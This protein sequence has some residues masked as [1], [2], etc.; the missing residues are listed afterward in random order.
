ML[1]ATTGDLK[2]GQFGMPVQASEV[3]PVIDNIFNFITWICIFF[4]VIIV[5]FIVFFMFKYSKPPG[6]PATSNVTHNTPIEVAWTVLPL[7]LVIFIF[8]K[9][10][11]GYIDLRSAPLGAYEVNVVAQK[12]N[13]TFHYKNGATTSVLIVPANRPVKLIMSSQ[14]VLHAL[15]IPD[16]RVKQDVVP[17]RI[18]TLW[19]TAI[20]AGEYDLYCAEYCGQQHSTML[21]KVIVLDDADFDTRITEEANYIDKIPPDMLYVAGP[22][23]YMRC[24]SCH[25]LDGSDMTGPTWQGLWDRTVDGEQVFTDGTTLSNLMG[26]GKLFDGP[27]DYVTQ[28]IN[29]PQQKIRM[30][31][32]GSMPTFKGQL[33][34]LEVMAIIDFLKHLDK[35]DTDGN[36][37]DS[38]DDLATIL[39]AAKA[40][41]AA[42][43]NE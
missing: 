12:W 19:F 39:D 42:S 36:P 38:A 3:A 9:G 13:W 27:E 30:N 34:P 21:T 16:F 25:S 14:D 7:I 37:L 43:S 29:N 5:G 1:L 23:L 15:F 10:M 40:A 35:F 20:K 4:F 28:S 18:T 33:G 2:V 6:T 41:E 32:S 31:Y 8:Y 22:R 26:A 24:K 11:D 17:G